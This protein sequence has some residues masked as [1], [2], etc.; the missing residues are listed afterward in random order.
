MGNVLEKKV[1]FV[2]VLDIKNN[3]LCTYYLRIDYYFL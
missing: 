1:I 3:N 2:H